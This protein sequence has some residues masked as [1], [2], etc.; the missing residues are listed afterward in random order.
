MG[1]VREVLVKQRTSVLVIPA[2]PTDLF[3]RSPSLLRPAALSRLV[4]VTHIMQTLF[5]RRYLY[6]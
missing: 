6:C 4:A 5:G 2:H 1:L 3:A